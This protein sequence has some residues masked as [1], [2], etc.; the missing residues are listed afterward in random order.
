[1]KIVIPDKIDLI[2]E[3]IDQIR[4]LG[5]VTIY[6]DTPKTEEEILQRIAG[7][8]IITANFIDIT[9]RIISD[10]IKAS[11][12]LKYIIVPAVGYEW[13]DIKTATEKG[14][15]ILNCP[16]QNAKAVA[17]YT[18]ALIFAVTRQIVT[19][20]IAL[21]NEKWK[22]D[23]SAYKGIELSGK[24][25][26]LIGYG[27][28]GKDVE[29]LAKALGME[30]IYANSKTSSEELD[31]LVSSADII[32]L[33]APLTTS[34]NNILNEKRLRM[35]KKGSY[36]INTARGAEVDQ[37]TLAELL[38]NGHLA[39]AALDVFVNEPLTGDPSKEIVKLANMPTVVATPHIAFNTEETDKR[40]GDELIADIKSCIE[41]NPINT[42][43]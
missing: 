40:L 32:S 4:S 28:I 41:G 3:H 23:I 30:V 27:N 1:M 35:M 6:N 26:G 11:S 12:T 36:L 8:E 20:D 42:V 16:T 18:I 37:K 29:Q 33:H 7:A 19:A 15:K 14:I 5:D 25:L 10:I 21:R 43:N 31:H 34:T 13:V 38:E 17:N 9:A 2:Q 39:G 22:E 24:K